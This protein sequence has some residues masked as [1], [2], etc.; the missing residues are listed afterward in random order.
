MGGCD[1]GVGDGGVMVVVAVVVMVEGTRKLSLCDLSNA[2]SF[3][4]FKLK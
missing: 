4:K 1:C 3:T 2:K